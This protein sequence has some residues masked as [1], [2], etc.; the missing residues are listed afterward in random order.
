MILEKP[1]MGGEDFADY[2]EKV[3]GNFIY[4]GTSKGKNTSYPWHHSNFNID[5]RALPKASAYLVFCAQK[6]LSEYN[7]G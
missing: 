3:R 7:N 6:L 2:L 1:S 4:I 5:E